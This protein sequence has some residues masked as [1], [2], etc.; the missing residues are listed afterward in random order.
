MLV[1]ATLALARASAQASASARRHPAAD[2]QTFADVPPSHPYYNEIEWLYRNGYTAGCA[3]DPL[4]YCPDV[5]MNRAESAVFVE[6]GIHTASHDPAV[7]TSQVFADLALDSWAAKWVNGLWQDQYTAGC[8]TNPLIYCPW[9][10]H[11]RAEG[12]V[13][14]LRMLNGPAFVPE[15]PI[16]QSFVDV[17]LDTWYAKWVQAAYDAGL[18]TPCQTSPEMRFCPDDPLLRGLSAYM[19]VQAKSG[20]IPTPTTVPPTVTP[21]PEPTPTQIPGF[22]PPEYSGLVFADEFNGSS[23]DPA[24]WEIMGDDV[25]RIGWWFADF[26]TVDGQGHLLIKTDK[27]PGAYHWTQWGEYIKNEW[28]PA[29][30]GDFAF[31]SGAIRTRDR[32]YN[33]F[34]YYETR[35]QF[36]GDRTA[37]GHWPAF[38]IYDESVNQVGN[39]GRDGTE[40]DIFEYWETNLFTHALHWDGYDDAAQ[41]A[42]QYVETQGM[43]TGFHLFGLLWTPTEY[44]FYIDG[45]ETWRTSAGGVSQVPEYVKITDEIELWYGDVNQLADLPH[46]TVF[47]YVRV[48]GPTSP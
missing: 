25:R 43:D 7:P 3:T 27:K 20:P 35:V 31:G 34:G 29:S 12:C 5:T 14:Y 23:I 36:L 48:Y 33:S 15:Q 19:M 17:P 26:A 11:S 39:E 32:F 18:I 8:G 6:R 40:I 4:R 28:A 10:G 13:F 16:Q 24:K 47:D 30:W 2:S 1:F 21:V 44:V 37:P 45:I 42:M 9:Q 38:W 22:P 46:F 41:D